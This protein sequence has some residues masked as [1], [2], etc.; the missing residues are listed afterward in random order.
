M[1]L[2]CHPYSACCGALVDM[3]E[4]HHGNHF[5]YYYF[6]RR[7]GHVRKVV[8]DERPFV[9][10]DIVN[11]SMENLE[12]INQEVIK[13]FQSG[14]VTRRWDV[15]LKDKTEVGTPLLKLKKGN[16]AIRM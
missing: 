14:S 13:C 15:V 16:N 12:E 7:C 11:W 8:V 6:C 3:E 2:H 9:S 5:K 4:Q 10:G 1:P